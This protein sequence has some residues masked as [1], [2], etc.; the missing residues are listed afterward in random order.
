MSMPSGCFGFKGEK[1]KTTELAQCVGRR[2]STKLPNGFSCEKQHGACCPVL[3]WQ[4]AL[5]VSKLMTSFLDLQSTA[6]IELQELL[7]SISLLI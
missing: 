4:V 5:K 3:K 1:E 2:F 6:R 7:F